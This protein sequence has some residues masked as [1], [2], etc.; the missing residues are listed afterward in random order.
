[1]IDWKVLRGVGATQPDPENVRLRRTLENMTEEDRKRNR[2][3]EIVLEPGDYPTPGFDSDQIRKA[4]T[5]FSHVPV[6]IPPLTPPLA[7]W[8]FDRRIM[9]KPVDTAGWYKY[10]ER[11]RDWFE[12]HYIDPAPFLD[13]MKDIVFPNKDWPVDEDSARDLKRG[14]GSAPE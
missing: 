4:V 13:W 8:T 7:W 12:S 10:Y 6:P 3:V 5:D 11:T 2:R 9:P 14:S 1:M